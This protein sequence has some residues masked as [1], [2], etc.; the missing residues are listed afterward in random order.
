MENK[1]FKTMILIISFF[2]I[3]MLFGYVMGYAQRTIQLKNDHG[4]S[5]QCYDSY[6][7]NTKKFYQKG[8]NANIT[9]TSI[10]QTILID[11]NFDDIKIII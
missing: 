7:S 4:I 5:F 1:K 8:C 10:N 6:D 11:S 2:M 3:T 9:I